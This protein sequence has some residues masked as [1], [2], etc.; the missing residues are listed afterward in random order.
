MTD[1]I[2]IGISGASG[3]GK[4]LITK[5]II[6][7][8]GDDKISII[9][10]DSYYKDLS[11]IPFN[12]RTGKN[13]DHPDA[14]EH[15]LLTRDLTDLKNG[16]DVQIPVYDYKTHTRKKKTNTISPKKVIILE[17]ILILN[18][19]SIRELLDIRVYVDAMPDICF[20]RRLQR[21]ISERRRTIESIINQYLQ[22]VR[23]MFLK[24]VEPSKKY[25]GL[26]LFSAFVKREFDDL[27]GDVLIPDT[28]KYLS[29]KLRVR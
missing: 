23:P 25:S 7:N 10:E 2:L 12:D 6:D 19:P 17:G 5:T 4:T 22:T 28:N 29:S 9:Q 15:D 13:F 24:F 14:F 26:S 11:D 18:D 20:I 27:G 8:I 21:D 3:S 1:A 16:I